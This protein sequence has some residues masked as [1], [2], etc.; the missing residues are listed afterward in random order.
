MGPHVNGKLY[1]VL[2]WTIA[3]GVSVLSLVLI[4]MTGMEWVG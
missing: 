4:V 3:V 2:A 1:N